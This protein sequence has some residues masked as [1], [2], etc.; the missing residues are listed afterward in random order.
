MDSRFQSQVALMRMELLQLVDVRV[1]EAS[2]P[3]R[4]EVAALKL[5]LERVDVSLEPVEAR[6][7]DGLGLAKAQAPVA[8]DSSEQMSS[9]VEE[10]HL[11]GCCSPRGPL[12]PPNGSVASE[13]VGMVMIAAQALD[14]ELSADADAGVCPSFET[15]RHVVA[16]SGDSTPAHLSLSRMS[17]ANRWLLSQEC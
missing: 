3:L 8:L 1:E 13:R 4:E 11:Y 15:G 10:E 6:P 12:S 7:S 5:L 16:K 17:P 14:N 9:V 2:R